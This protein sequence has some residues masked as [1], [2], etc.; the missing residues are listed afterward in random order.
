MSEETRIK[1]K[2]YDEEMYYKYF[3]KMIRAIM[4]QIIGRGMRCQRYRLLFQSI[5]QKNI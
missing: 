1:S 5:M 3:V 2:Q 4:E